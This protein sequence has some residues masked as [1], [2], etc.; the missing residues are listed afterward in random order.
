ME[1]AEVD[2]EEV[3]DIPLTNRHTIKGALHFADVK[4]VLINGE[5]DRKEIDTFVNY[6]VMHLEVSNNSVNIEL[7]SW[8]EKDAQSQ[9]YSIVNIE[10]GR[11]YWEDF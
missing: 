7:F 9:D 4:H 10:A 11:I 5:L 3:Q 2:P 1:S 6:E 8:G